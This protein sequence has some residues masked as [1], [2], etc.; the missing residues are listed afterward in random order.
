M[1]ISRGTNDS[2]FCRVVVPN[3]GSAK[4]KE[5]KMF[6]GAGFGDTFMDIFCSKIFF[7]LLLL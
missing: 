1:V 6:H 5:G 2:S 7:G 4:K 3:Q